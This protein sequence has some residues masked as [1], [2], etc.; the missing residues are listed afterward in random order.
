M[1]GG[2]NRQGFVRFKCRKI[3]PKVPESV[4]YLVCC[5][6]V[7]CIYETTWQYNRVK[8]TV[9]LDALKTAEVTEEEKKYWVLSFGKAVRALRLAQGLSQEEFALA[10]GLSRPHMSQ[11]EGGSVAPGVNTLVS[12]CEGLCLPATNLMTEWAKSY[13]KGKPRHARKQIPAAFMAKRP[14]AA[15]G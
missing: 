1:G 7:L 11:I 13:L 5:F 4:L 9:L 14:P 12:L 3:K 15:A 8:K 2:Q 6:L 10:T